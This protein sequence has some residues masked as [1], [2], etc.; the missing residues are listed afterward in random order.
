[1]AP[2]RFYLLGRLHRVISK[3]R[4]FLSFELR[5]WFL[6][7][8]AEGGRQQFRFKNRLW[9]A[10]ALDSVFSHL[11]PAQAPA[12]WILLYLLHTIILCQFE[13]QSKVAVILYYAVN[14]SL[15]KRERT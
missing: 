1:M 13:L 8:D 3:V 2:K 12:P 4:F 5:R 14:V 10:P 11:P 6:S 7:L 15:L 9:S